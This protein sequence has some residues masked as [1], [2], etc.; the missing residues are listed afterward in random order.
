[1]FLFKK[2]EKGDRLFLVDLTSVSFFPMNVINEIA[3][4]ENTAMYDKAPLLYLVMS[5]VKNFT[6][7]K[8]KRELVYG[9]YYDTGAWR[10]YVFEKA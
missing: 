1:M 9:G 7:E 4:A 10:I 5:Y 6:L 3:S 2:L 8:A